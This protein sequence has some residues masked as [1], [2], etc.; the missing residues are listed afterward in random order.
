MRSASSMRW[1]CTMNPSGWS[2][3]RCGEL[4]ERLYSGGAA[5]ARRD[6]GHDHACRQG[7]GVGRGDPA[8][9]RP[10]DRDRH[11][12]AAAL[13]RAAARRATAPI[14][15]WRRFARPTQE[16]RG[17]LAAYIK[18]LRRERARLERVRLLYVAA[19]R[20]RSALHLLAALPLPANAQ[21]AG[22]T[23]RLIA[24]SCCGRRSASNSWR[25]PRRRASRAWTRCSRSPAR[26]RSR[27]RCGGCRP[28]WA[29]PDTP[30]SACRAVRGCGWHRPAGSRRRNI[31]G[32]DHRARGRHHRA[33]RTAS[34]GNA[35]PDAAP[36]RGRQRAAGLRRLAGRT[37]RG[38]RTNAPAPGA[39]VQRGARSARWPIRAAA[40]C[41]RTRTSR[42]QRMAADRHARTAAW[43]MSSSIA[44][45]WTSRG[46]A[47]SW[48]SRP[49]RTRAVPSA[50]SSTRSRTLSTAAAALRGAGRAAR[51]RAG[52]P[53]AVFS[54]ARCVPRAR[55]RGGL[56]AATRQTDRARAPRAA[57]AP[58]RL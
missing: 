21:A 28:T 22:A 16:P 23:R 54:A 10:Q 31:A 2:A 36:A 55:C 18:R 41:C 3:R 56:R 58:G 26:T 47:G 11:R 7:P 4:T 14:C 17:S 46:S 39:L 19:T 35:A 34:P 51:P 33:C 25:W 13:D 9:T 44:C 29:L 32:W 48:I 6:R 27:R 37:R 50:S 30:A 43:S 40:G 53:G 49:A 12:S 20:A 15:C 1:R 24:R 45:W 52:A 38:Q 42:P 57:G 8:W 5:A